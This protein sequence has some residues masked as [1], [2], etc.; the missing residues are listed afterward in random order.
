M[1]VGF[2]N[3]GNMGSA[4][5]ANLLVAGHALTVYNRTHAN[6]DILVAKGARLVKTS[7]DAAQGEIVITMLADRR[8]WQTSS[9]TLAILSSRR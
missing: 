3:L 5:A 2:I 7:A 6:V 1:Q 8:L 4:M 9:R